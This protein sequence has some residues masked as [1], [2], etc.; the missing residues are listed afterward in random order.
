VLILIRKQPIWPFANRTALMDGSTDH[1]IVTIA[2]LNNEFFY[3]RFIEDWLDSDSN[4]DS[5]LMVAVASVLHEESNVYMPQWRGSLADRA[6]NLDRNRE[7]DHMQLYNDYFH[8][9]MALYRNYFW[10]R[11]RIGKL[12]KVFSTS[13][14]I[15]NASRMPHVNL[16]SLPIKNDW[17]LCECLLM[18]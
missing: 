7:A 16:A 1:D 10:C 4:D 2:S 8:P 6:G 11:F 12:L 13:S 15:S 9:D 17:R 5:D 14:H 3:K 18:E